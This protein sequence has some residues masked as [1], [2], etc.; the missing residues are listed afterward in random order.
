MRKNFFDYISHRCIRLYSGTLPVIRIVLNLNKVNHVLQYTI[1]SRL[2]RFLYFILAYE[3]F[4]LITKTL[5]NPPNTLVGLR[6]NTLLL[7]L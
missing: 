6:L 7:A 2:Y 5:I 3:R 1:D 4:D